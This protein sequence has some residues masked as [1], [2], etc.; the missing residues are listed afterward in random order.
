MISQRF[1]SH[2]LILLGLLALSSCRP[3]SR[4][5]P[6]LVLDQ[7]GKVSVT[8]DQQPFSLT[9]NAWLQPGTTI[10][11]PKDGRLDL[12]LLPGMLL[13]VS[14][15]AELEILELRVAK[16]G[17]E[18]I[19]P[20]LGREARVRLRRGTVLAAVRPS[21][22][23]SRLFF[24]TV[25]GEFRAGAGRVFKLIANQDHVRA[26]CV[27]GE[28]TLAAAGNGSKSRIKPGY[29]LD[30]PADSD[31]PRAAATADHDIQAEI[32]QIL[33]EEKRLLLLARE[34]RSVFKR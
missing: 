8:V 10:T 31:G 19:H 32:P 13:E 28:T 16:D 6:A 7:E 5:V 11:V 18:N 21:Q 14:G 22:T 33:K 1:V 2:A 20:M 29:F 3:T 12:M 27:R 25:A 30:W 4:S 23:R 15:D 26:I 24:E 9:T 17:D 34:N